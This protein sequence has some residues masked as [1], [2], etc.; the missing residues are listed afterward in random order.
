MGSLILAVPAALLGS[1]AWTSIRTGC[2][3]TRYRQWDAAATNIA[4]GAV[5][6]GLATMLAIKALPA[7]H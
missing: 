2:E 7:R 4:I 3:W 1:I 5:F 6:G